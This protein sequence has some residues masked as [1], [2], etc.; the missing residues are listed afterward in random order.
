MMVLATGC[1]PVA[2][3]PPPT[4]VPPGVHR[5]HGVSLS[6]GTM[7]E[8]NAGSTPYFYPQFPMGGAQVFIRQEISPRLDV[9]GVVYLNRGAGAGATVRFWSVRADRLSVGHTLSAGA[10]Y[11]AGGLPVQ[12]TFREAATVHIQPTIGMVY[13]PFD[14]FGTKPVLLQF[15]V[16]ITAH[17]PP[18]PTPFRNLTLEVIPEIRQTA[19]IP[20]GAGELVTGGTFNGS[21]SLMVSASR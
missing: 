7:F 6:A 15:P 10:S 13:S 18:A 3:S 9:A 17:A 1:V 5:E 11:A 2:L 4:H 8:A 14:L 20:G 19:E 12:W 16:G 21:I